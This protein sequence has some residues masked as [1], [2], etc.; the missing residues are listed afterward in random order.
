[1]ENHGRSDPYFRF[2]RGENKFHGIYG[3]TIELYLHLFKTCHGVCAIAFASKWV[4]LD[5]WKTTD[6]KEV[7]NQCLNHEDA[8][9]YQ[10]MDKSFIYVFLST[11]FYCC[12]KLR[13]FLVHDSK[14]FV[15]EAVIY[16]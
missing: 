5:N 10:G 3:E 15:G 11:L 9:C 12:W 7:L 14:D 4:Y 8:Q 16:F 1:M 13:N 6:M 2:S